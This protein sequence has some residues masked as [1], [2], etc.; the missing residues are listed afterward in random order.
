MWSFI[1]KLFASSL[2]RY[3]TVFLVGGGITL[4]LLKVYWNYQDLVEKA[5]SA[6]ILKLEMGVMEQQHLIEIETYKARI[7]NEKKARAIAEQ[8][9][10][11]NDE[12]REHWRQS[13]YKLNNEFV[14]Y[15]QAT[16]DWIGDR[17]PDELDGLRNFIPQDR[18]GDSTGTSNNFPERGGLNDT[19]FDA[20]R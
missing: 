2:A 4:A 20:S 7:A 13:W 1:V 3:L 8:N 5:A 11:E 17:Y 12:R 18:S 9:E 19:P 14:D 6:D 16:R 15:Q 10:V